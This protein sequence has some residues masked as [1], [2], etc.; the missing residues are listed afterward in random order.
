LV[1]DQVSWMQSAGITHLFTSWGGFGH[2]TQKQLFDYLVSELG[3]VR[4]GLLMEMGR[5][6][7]ESGGRTFTAD[8]ENRF[9]TEMDLIVREI[10]LSG[11]QLESKYWYV[12]EPFAVG[13]GTLQRPVFFMYTMR[14]WPDDVA[15]RFFDIMRN[16]FANEG[17]APPYIVGDYAFGRPRAVDING[18]SAISVYDTYAQ[19]GN[20]TV[21]AEQ[22]ET[23]VD[24]EAWR[25]LNP[26]LGI[27]PTVSPGYSDISHRGNP[28]LSPK[29]AT[30]T[31]FPYN[32]S[33]SL[34]KKALE[35]VIS[36]GT[37]FIAINSWNEWQETSNIEPTSGDRGD[38]TGESGNTYYDFGVA[39]LNILAQTKGLPLLVDATPPI[40]SAEFE[41]QSS[42]EKEIDIVNV[43]FGPSPD[44]NSVAD[45]IYHP[46]A[47]T[48]LRSFMCR[49]QPLLY[50]VRAGTSAKTFN[51]A[52]F[53]SFE[54]IDGKITPVN[55]S[56]YLSSLYYANRGHSTIKVWA[57]FNSTAALG[58]MH[59]VS[60][61]EGIIPSI[62]VENFDIGVRAEMI[63]GPRATEF[64][65]GI[66]AP[67]YRIPYFSDERF[68]SQRDG[69][70]RDTFAKHT[71]VQRNADRVMFF[72]QYAGVEFY[73]FLGTPA[74]EFV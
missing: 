22:V 3:P 54:V 71:Y 6:K 5:F 64:F 14:A 72:Q 43:R 36:L 28:P 10:F 44:V 69:N 40:T 53:P 52:R 33:T 32:D 61:Q 73:Y 9:T 42:H 48:S 39:Y 41:L 37:E 62:E 65:T 35:T 55:V 59:F 51:V 70:V 60:L 38:Q 8:V 2:R 20:G 1:N 23:A 46:D 27:I 45:V 18:L 30:T 16:A 21:T 15:E 4:Y 56:Q 26:Q 7:D 24:W 19:I 34:F 67:E 66:D 29:L 57:N 49:T 17:L 63:Y 47:H 31:S 58:N 13:G 11:G 12:E 74:I 50:D 25:S 68:K